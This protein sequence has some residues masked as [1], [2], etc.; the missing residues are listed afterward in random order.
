MQ[1]GLS[2]REAARIELIRRVVCE[3][4][5]LERAFLAAARLAARTLGVA[6]VGIWCFD[7]DER[8][9]RCQHLYRAADDQWCEPEVIELAGCPHYAEAL[10]T[11]RVVASHDVLTDP[12]TSELRP[13]LTKHGIT[14]MLDSPIFERGHPV[15]IVC[16]EHVG[17]PRTWTKEESN[18]ATTVADMLGLY[19]EQDA[20]Q[21]NYRALLTTRAELERARVME[22]VGRLAAGV[23]HDFNNILGAISMSSDLLRLRRDPT[24]AAVAVTVGETQALV[25]QG[26]RLVKQLLSVGRQAQTS[27]DGIDLVG[28]VQ[29]MSTFL[30]TLE[31]SGICVVLQLSEP[32]AR[33]PLDR[34]SAEQV[35]MN[36]AVNARDAMLGGGTLTIE[37]KRTRDDVMAERVQLNVSDSGIGM[38]EHTRDRIFEPYFST[39]PPGQGVGL[40][41][42]TV[43]RIVKDSGGL[44]QVRSSLGEGTTF[45]LS[46]PA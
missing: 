32:H 19:L 24:A 27:A 14:S 4:E 25:E 30:R 23:A 26:A 44:I 20:T 12:R 18:F 2:T 33:V 8:R 39:K 7:H 45:S 16:H 41:L 11:F 37:V 3:P 21:R 42:A 13:Y 31:P 22:S 6:R 38:D 46:W 29:G 9:I 1:E 10:R 36:L 35:L 43:Y 17:S 15:G 28:V 5:A 34:S 40:G